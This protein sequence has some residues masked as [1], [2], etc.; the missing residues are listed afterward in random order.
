[1]VLSI[2][3][4]CNQD[5]RS[6]VYKFSRPA[7]AHCSD[8]RQRRCFFLIASLQFCLCKHAE[9]DFVCGKL[10]AYI[11]W[12]IFPKLVNAYFGY[13]TIRI[14]GGWRWKCF[15]IKTIRGQLKIKT[16]LIFILLFIYSLSVLFF[17]EAGELVSS[18]KPCILQC[19]GM[20]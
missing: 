7:S 6:F 4:W 5:E 18:A 16:R 13:L 3:C 19:A 1:M 10:V 20:K 2:S 17:P 12:A 15:Y 14:Q 9:F 11:A 8:Q